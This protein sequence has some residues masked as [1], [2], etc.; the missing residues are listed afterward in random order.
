M[1]D[2]KDQQKGAGGLGA[3]GLKSLKQPIVPDVAL[4]SRPLVRPSAEEMGED[5]SSLSDQELRKLLKKG[6]RYAEQ[7]NWEKAVPNLIAAWEAMP[8][9][10]SLLTLIAH[11]LSCL[12]VREYAVSVLERALRFHEP[13]EEICSIM[14]S[15][16]IDMG[17]FEIAVK[18]GLILVTMAPTKSNYYVNLA[19]AYTGAKMLDESIDMLQNILPMFPDDPEL[20]NVLATQVRERDGVDAAD[21]FFEESLRLDPENYKTISNY[22]MSFTRRNQYDKALELTLKS[23]ELEPNS[24]EPQIGAAVIHFLQGKMDLAWK[25]YE[26]RLSTR[27]KISQTQV[28]THGLPE[29]KGEDLT[30]KTLFVTAEQGIGDEV[31]FG[32]YLPYLYD[33][34]D[35]LVIGCQHRL[36]SLYKRRFPNAFVD[37]CADRVIQGYRYRTFPN[38]ENAIDDG[39][40]SVDFA[41]TVGSAPKFEWTS[42]DTI[43]PHPDGF[44]QA[45]PERQAHFAKTFSAISDKP[46]VGLAWRSGVVTGERLGMYATIDE[47]GPLMAFADKVDF[48]N[49]QYGDCTSELAAIK[50]KYGATVHDIEGVDLMQD[51]EANIAMMANCAAVVSSCSA[52]GMFA[53]SSGRPTILMSAAQPWWCFGDE[54]TIKFAK[55][56]MYVDGGTNIEW[57]D[58]IARVAT[59]LEKQLSI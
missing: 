2:E 59:N 58:I 13:N 37:F 6:S 31:M 29:W 20:W 52:P 57:P 8:N 30:G 35:K 27:R 34:A 15:L 46:K 14:L 19:T 25:A 53:L 24:P 54:S 41:I 26:A 10:I 16:A 11:G 23:C 4:D 38:V 43:Q 17:M 5:A 1:P 44:L 50:E 22:A 55:A 48:I 9:D 42:P 12:G 7:G 28:Y 47:L 40:L 21:V 33:R 39:R 32:N 36:E 51:I 3:V 45:D 49:L 18:V 56:A